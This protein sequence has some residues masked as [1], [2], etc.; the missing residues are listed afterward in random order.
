M[1]GNRSSY[2]VSRVG[3][4]MRSHFKRTGLDSPKRTSFAG[5]MVIHVWAQ[6]NQPFG[7]NNHNNCYFVGDT[8]YSY[9]DGFIAARFVTSPRGVKIVLLNS[10][11]YS[12]TTRDQ[13]RTAQH[14]T[15]QYEQF[16]VAHLGGDE[17]SHERNLK[18]M[19]AKAAKALA[20]YTSARTLK[21]R[22][23]AL[24]SHEHFASVALAYQRAFFP[25]KRSVP[26][27]PHGVDVATL[28]AQ[29]VFADHVRNYKAA[30]RNAASRER[31][32]F[33]PRARASNYRDI[34]AYAVKARR[35]NVFNEPLAL[36]QNPK[37][38]LMLWRKARKA[39]KW[40][41]DARTFDHA[42][43]T[44]QFD[45]PYSNESQTPRLFAPRAYDRYH[46]T[47]FKTFDHFATN[48]RTTAQI[49]A[50]RAD[51]ERWEAEYKA[52][53]E[54]ERQADAKKAPELIA[55]WRAGSPTISKLRRLPCM[56]RVSPRDGDIVESSWGV[57]FPA[58]HARKAWRIV[59]RVYAAGI[60]WHKNGER[61]RVGHFEID[62]IANDG[63]VTA[64][65][66]TIARAEIEALAASLGVA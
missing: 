17:Y 10:E 48:M 66:H 56:L 5:D 13:I 14:A 15:R 40:E 29:K 65:C 64:G 33:T 59:S 60:A 6:Q 45:S 4:R 18:D 19:V 35:A 53:M 47:G 9:A 16:T 3:E 62:A 26:V 58:D 38:I 2:E 27:K 11:G 23:A 22:I 39:I 32:Y 43:I 1:Y 41:R 12:N 31:G 63:T 7:K 21:T 54:A 57:D 46:R 25:R 37:R 24:D 28:R 34:I 61:A 30:I 8:L 36:P 52:R 42:I 44:A 50:A 20:T 51:R 55:D 49:E